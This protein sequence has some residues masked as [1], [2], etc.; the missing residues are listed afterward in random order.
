MNV[1]L[2]ELHRDKV[3]RIG[4][5]RR[6]GSRDD[7]DVL[8]HPEQGPW[9]RPFADGRQLRIPGDRDWA[10]EYS[11]SATAAVVLVRPG[12]RYSLWLNFRGG[13]FE[14]WYVNFERESAW[15][16]ACFDL[17]DEK[18]DLV[19]EPG[20]AVRWKDEDELEEAARAGYLDAGEVRAEAERVLARPP[21]PTGWE[22]FEPDPSWPV[23]EL[24]AGWEANPLRSKR[25]R[26]TPL[27]E[28]DLGEYAGLRSD[29]RTRVYSR[30][31]LPLSLEQSRAELDASCAAWRQHGFGSW[32]VR[33]LAGAFIGVIVAVPSARDPA[34]PDFGWLVVPERW[35]EGLATEAARL[36]VADLLERRGVTHFTS[37]LQ[38]ANT[39]SRRVA[40][41][42]GMRLRE[43]GPGRGGELVAAYEL[44]AGV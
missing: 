8:W 18:L 24:P 14:S 5:A 10:L 20:G 23:P 33:T 21:W 40:E 31:G 6:V 4:A 37:Y 28:S 13:V 19:I 41:K 36:V 9:Y 3:W 38:A 42:L 12:D 2:R 7:F 43:T 44:R 16:G 25:L 39:A 1:A 29:P 11:P 34:S 17:V 22:N 32:C 30:T 27:A 35:G 26:L 15:H